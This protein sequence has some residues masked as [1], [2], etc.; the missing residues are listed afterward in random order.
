MFESNKLYTNRYKDKYCWEELD[1]RYVF[2]MTGDWTKYCRMG[3]KEDE[4]GLDFN[5]LGMFDPSGGPYVSLGDKIDGKFIA[6]ISQFEDT[7]V[8][9]VE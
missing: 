5:D 8:V 2:R 4:E 7:F 3:G 6:K 9:E 1:G